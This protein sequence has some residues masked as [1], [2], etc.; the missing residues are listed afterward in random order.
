MLVAPMGFDRQECLSVAISHCHRRTLYRVIH[1][2]LLLDILRKPSQSI[3]IEAASSLFNSL[4]T[5]HLF[6]KK[7][8]MPYRHDNFYENT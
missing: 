3:D 5:T 8:C 2:E 6:K 7:L 1:D 4:A